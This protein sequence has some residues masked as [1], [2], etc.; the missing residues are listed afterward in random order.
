MESKIN[1]DQV[2]KLARLSLKPEEKGKLSKDL[3]NILAYVDLL[4][5]LDTS[6]VEPTSHVLPIENVFRKD[7]V[8]ES[9]VRNFV[10]DHAPKR[11]GKFFKVPKVIEG[12]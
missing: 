11:D 7:K 3:E 8:I 4:Q 6:K 9:G 5:E 10:L 12:L 1:I 2:A